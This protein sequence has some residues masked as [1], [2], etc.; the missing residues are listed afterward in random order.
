MEKKQAGNLTGCAQLMLKIHLAAY[1]A[2][3]LFEQQRVAIN[4]LVHHLFHEPERRPFKLDEG[5]KEQ[6]Q[7]LIEQKLGEIHDQAQKCRVDAG[8]LQRM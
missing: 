6:M 3:W 4:T 1:S 7:H 5:F 8:Q 2:G